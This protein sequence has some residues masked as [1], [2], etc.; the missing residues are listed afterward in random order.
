MERRRFVAAGIAGLAALPGTSR[1]QSS[2]RVPRVG[3]LNNLN[4]AVGAPSVDALLQGL[5]ERGWNDGGNVTIVYRWADGDMSRHPALA[6]ELV[7]LPVDV[8][9]TAG[10][11]AV[12]AARQA[13]T[14][15]PIVV[16]IMPDPVALGFVASFAR[17]G[18]NVT[19]LANVFEEL[20][21]KQL[22]VFREVVPGAKRIALLTDRSTEDRILA[23]TEAAA[24]ALGLVPLTLNVDAPREL[25]ASMKTARSERADGVLVLPSPFFNRYRARIADLANAQ[26]LPTISES[27]EYVVDGGL[28]SYGP[29]FP[30]MYFRA[31]TYVD[32]VL[33]GEKP[34]DLAIER[35]TTFELAVNLKTA[36][37]L[38]IDVPKDV[39]L[40]ADRVIR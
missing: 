1:A 3:I 5:R 11:Q 10:T 36:K 38:A 21:P 6:A 37:A 31:A 2:R 26:R 25:D 29:N 17:P 40:R 20:T 4:P 9:V 14:T 23:V 24:R 13:T 16:A 27:T 12:R 8:I 15:I 35:P 32:R 28:L 34:G 33:R 39:L 22:Q 19:G 18:G 7:K 30:Q